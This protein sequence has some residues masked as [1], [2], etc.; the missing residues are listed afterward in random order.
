ML[1]SR[2]FGWL[3]KPAMILIAISPLT[4]AGPDP[5]MRASTSFHHTQWDGVGAVFDIKQSLDG[6]LW[7]TT[8]K[9]VLRFDGVR[10]QSVAEATFGAVHANEIDSV[11]FS[12]SGGLWL[13]TESAGLLFWK[14]GK[15]SEF[16][17]RRCTP[18]RKQGKIVE[19]RDGSLWVQGAGGLFRLRG[20][21]CEAIGAKQGYP[22]GFAAGIL[23][24]SQGT[25]WVK[26]RKGPLLFL[27]RGQSKFQVNDS[28]EG[29]STSYAFLH[30]A[31]DGA[32]WL[33]DD[34]G[35]RRVTGSPGTAGFSIPRAQLAAKPSTYGDFS[36]APDGSLWATNAKGVERFE[37]V[38][39]W[40]TPIATESASAEAFT[41][42]N[43]LSS[44]AAWKILI[45]REGVTW[46]G[47]NSGLDRLRRN[48]LSSVALPQ[49]QEREFAIAPGDEDSL[50]VGNSG[51]SL[52][53]VAASG[54]IISFPKTV[55]PI[56]IR[57]DHT[58]A[59]WASGVGGVHL[60]R[61]SG[62]G[63]SPVHYPDE[64]LDAVVSVAT[65][66]NN[67]PW[68]LTRSGRVY[69]FSGDAWSNQ[70]K[71]LGRK[72]G[73]I[74]AMTD[75]P[76]G[77]V[78]L[79]FSDRVVQWDGAAFHTSIRET[80][81]VSE[82]TMS[83]R[84]DRVWLGG[85][86]GVQ[87]FRAG[88]FYNLRWKDAELPGRISGVIESRTGEL[89]A[90]GFS[91][92]THVPASELSKWLADPGYEVFAERLDEQDGLPGLSGE[93]IPEPSVIET[94]NGRLFFA[95]TKGVAWLDPATLAQNR[96]RVPPPIAISAVLSNGKMYPASAEVKLPAR[97]ENL[98]IDYTA[99][100][101]AM[102][103]RVLFRY[104]LSGVDR[105]LEDAG[106]RREAYYTKLRPGR[107]QFRVSARN[108]DGVWNAAGAALN[109]DIAPAWFQTNWF[110]FLM[111]LACGLLASLLYRLRV[112]HIAAGMDARFE[113]RMAERTRIAQELHDTLLQGFLSASMQVH[114]AVD[115]LADDSTVKPILTRALQLMRQV[116]DEGRNA[117]RGLRSSVSSSLD[118]EQALSR[119]QQ[120][121][122]ETQAGR[123]DVDFRV[124]VDGQQREL[125]PV[126]RD[127]VYRIGR[128]ALI[129]A[130]RHSHAQ[131]IELELKYST[132]C[133]EMI[134]R[135]DGCG[136]DPRVLQTGREGHYGLFGMRER[137]D[138]IGASLH[139]MS[140]P[141]GGTEVEL[142]IPGKLAFQRG[143]VEDHSYNG[144]GPGQTRQNGKN[145]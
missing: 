15:V 6:Y 28:I 116:I 23:L 38:A 112:R 63:F 136:I 68:I 8:S 110:L 26:T 47:T 31:P 139:V 53:R 59:I 108:N 12:S 102:P 77:N 51:L 25:L 54:A 24:D 144:R 99:L 56:S 11:F 16:R 124:I 57:R 129:N 58:G 60:W 91:G 122:A 127:E 81:G 14:D 7:L 132:A 120:E 101:L 119:I 72:P 128:E 36:F 70:N 34:R 50:W 125:H 106:V 93:K 140:K 46:V 22:G 20:N 66:R 74:G 115:A 44:D 88:H 76:A 18:T 111:I 5:R 113:A 4:A 135:D 19:D 64:D 40:P 41:P 107:Y 95:T 87:L 104:Q 118:L 109:I 105:N 142:S 117:V 114:V 90:N 21:T 97:T 39:N 43:G 27:P 17:D 2:Q 48:A 37:D 145:R 130:F 65:D 3:I 96:N 94:P 35:L 9:G 138:R 69:H 141:S 133:L 78:W 45:D 80:R 79:A 86:G 83:V 1:K 121:V 123:E 103:E 85:S 52:M 10:F 32:V 67:D 55:Q 29:V 82:S 98:E 134:V 131:K 143:G 73:V 92:V 33:S 30:E 62:A 71:T 49:S 89:W 126:L 84:E 13:T 75:D 137:A 100:S 61:S 42:P